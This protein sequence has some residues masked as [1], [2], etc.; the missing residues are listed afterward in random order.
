ML[1]ALL[2]GLAQKYMLHAIG[3]LVI[4]GLLGGGILYIRHQGVMAERARWEVKVE[5]IRRE[6]EADY[7][8]DLKEA[9][10]R[11]EQAVAYQKTLD[12]KVD[13]ANDAVTK[14]PGSGDIIVP[15]DIVDRL[16]VI[17]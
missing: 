1:T 17:R 13:E 10:K 14:N 6:L 3:G 11:Y 8:S 12:E 2:A 9:Y 4:A 7:L 15:A 16:R 5:D